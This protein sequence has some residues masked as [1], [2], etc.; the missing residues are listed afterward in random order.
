MRQPKL[1]LRL[2]LVT[3]RG[4]M[5]ERSIDTVVAQ[6]VRGGATMVQLR[7]KECSTK[8]FV[9]L[10]RRLKNLLSPL[11]IPLIIN[12]RLDVAQ[13]VKAEGVHLGQKDMPYKVARRIL[14]P[15][16]IIGLSVES[17]ADAE[18]A[19]DW[20]VD[21][22]G[23]SP[24]YATPTKTDTGRPWGLEG[25]RE[26]RKITKHPLVAIGGINAE[27][28]SQVIEA[29]A[30]GVAVVSAICAATDPEGPARSILN[31]VDLSLSRRN[32]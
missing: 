27:N 20:D 10:G 6:A 11:E 18:E 22:F 12:D 21:Y 13:A 26:L 3:D 25:L 31:A 14:G 23:V 19:A 28:A 5:G 15:E 29:G 9:D 8:E 16:I 17:L 32:D 4:Y 2:Y 1:D 7:E 24:I 30:D